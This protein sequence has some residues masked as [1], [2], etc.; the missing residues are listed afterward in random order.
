[1]LT[2]FEKYLLT[3]VD[4]EH[5]VRLREEQLSYHLSDA[6]RFYLLHSL[7]LLIDSFW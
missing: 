5:I 3:D 7:L 1:M 6:V 2:K 4:A